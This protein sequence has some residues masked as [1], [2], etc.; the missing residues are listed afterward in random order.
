M[1][2][3]SFV[4]DQVSCLTEVFIDRALRRAAELDEH[5]KVTGKVVGPLH[6]MRAT[7]PS[8]IV[9]YTLLQDFRYR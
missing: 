2:T 1:I 3:L 7:L 4:V 9:T 5:L 8:V 6:G